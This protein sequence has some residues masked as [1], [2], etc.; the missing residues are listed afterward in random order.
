[1]HLNPLISDEESRYS[2]LTSWPWF[3]AYRV[4]AWDPAYG[5]C[6]VVKLAETNGCVKGP[7]PGYSFDVSAI[8]NGMFPTPEVVKH[9]SL[10]AMDIISTPLLCPS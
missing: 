3:N 7:Y 2:I 8:T 10:R 5:A 1:M 6:D 4:V 9:M